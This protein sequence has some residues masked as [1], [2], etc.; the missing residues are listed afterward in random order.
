MKMRKFILYSLFFSPLLVW[1]GGGWTQ[2]KG[3]GFYKLGQNVIIGTQYFTPDGSIEPITTISL[4]TTS[5]YAEYGITD[6][7]TGILYFPFF[8]RSTLNEERLSTGQLVTRGDAFNGL[9]DTDIS[10]KYGIT[11]GKQVALSA[12]LTFGLPLGTT[13]GGETGILQSG[14]GEFNQM[15][16]L[17]AGTGF[18][19]GIYAN[20]NL[21]FNNRTKKFSN[22]VR[23]GFESGWS[24]GKLTGLIRFIGI[25]PIGEE[26]APGNVNN[27]VFGNRIE[28]LSFTPE[29]LYLFSD[30]IGVSLSVG[31]AFYGK[32]ILANPN[33]GFGLFMK[34]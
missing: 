8:V 3:S 25:K 27:G 5:I 32:R 31:M 20:A 28:Y 19:N 12:S 22:E 26:E 7:I 4:Y 30:K 2:D 24:N 18:G 33:Y 29:T 15:I 17:D 16:S 14:D 9:G 6:R 21:G 34:L 10:I 11:K 13:D 23:Y 1:A